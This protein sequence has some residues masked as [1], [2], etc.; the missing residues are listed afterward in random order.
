MCDSE[1][2][3]TQM[4]EQINFTTQI[5][6]LNVATVHIFRFEEVATGVVL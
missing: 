2:Q 5:P 3:D 1:N 6:D 4:Q